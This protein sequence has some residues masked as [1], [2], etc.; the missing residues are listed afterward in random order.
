[1]RLFYALISIAGIMILLFGCAQKRETIFTVE[2]LIPRDTVVYDTVVVDTTQDAIDSSG[3]RDSIVSDTVVTIVPKSN[4]INWLIIVTTIFYDTTYKIEAIVESLTIKMAIYEKLIHDTITFINDDMDTKDTVSDTIITDIDS[5][6]E[7]FIKYT[8][9]GA[10][11]TIIIEADTTI[12]THFVSTYLYSTT[13][14][15]STG[16]LGYAI[17]DWMISDTIFTGGLD[18]LS[19]GADSRIFTYDNSVYIID[20]AHSLICFNSPVISNQPLYNKYIDTAGLHDISFASN[21]KA[22]LTQYKRNEILVV[23]PANGGVIKPI[24]LAPYTGI[25]TA[26]VPYMQCSKVYGNKLY[27]LCQRLKK[28]EGGVI[29]VGPLTGLVVVVSTVNDSILDTI[30]LAGKKPVSMD[31]CG[32][33]LYVVSVGSPSNSIIGGI[34]RIN[35][36]SNTNEELFAELTDFFDNMYTITIVSNSKGYVLIHTK[37]GNEIKPFE[38]NPTAYSDLTEVTGIGDA[39]GGM[40]YDGSFLY[41]GDRSPMNTGV[42]VIN[43]ADNRKVAGPIKMGLHA[44]SSVTVLTVSK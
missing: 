6:F 32:D 11:D 9:L 34:E 1:M 13:S 20:G 18:L 43:P 4:S 8:S 17:I 5:L 33:S 30:S 25:D 3:T 22:Y 23:D 40:D 42:V 16:N 36:I 27:V 35:L 24:D 41:V 39:S 38:F 12:D 14:D 10:I 28:G 7:K 37:S 21:T 44:P 26:E 19:I 29:E 31:I 15:G 2:T